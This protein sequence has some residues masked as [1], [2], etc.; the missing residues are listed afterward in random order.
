ML[1][2]KGAP[3]AIIARCASVPAGAAQVL[4]RLFA[5]GHTGRRRRHERRNGL[6][7]SD[8]ADERDLELRGFLCFSDPPKADAADS[9][10]R[11]ARLE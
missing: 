10:G 4:D 7:S 9:L 3:E 6:A 1:V 11:L 2:A 8:S 5:D